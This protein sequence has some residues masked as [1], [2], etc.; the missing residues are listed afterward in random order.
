M[1]LIRSLIVIVLFVFTLA[2]CKKDDSVQNPATG[3][4]IKTYTESINSSVLGVYSVTYNLSYDQQGRVTTIINAENAGDRFAYTYDEKR[5]DMDIYSSNALVIHQD[6]FLNGNRM[7]STF[8]YNDEGDT[9]TEKY[10]YNPANL[11]IKLNRYIYS[12]GVSELDETVDY[13]YDG[14]SNLISEIGTFTHIEYEYDGNTPGIINLFPLF[15][16][17][18]QK[19]PSRVID[20]AGYTAD[21]TYSV[22]SRNRVVSDVAVLSTG[23]V[24]TKTYTYE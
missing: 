14:S 13:T 10:V 21:H 23:D 3:D 18:S 19:M 4:K 9:T 1:N 8:Q 22:D 12:D 16:S 17:T 11:L 2:S 24:I 6:V 7:D 5:F 20:Q 15:Y